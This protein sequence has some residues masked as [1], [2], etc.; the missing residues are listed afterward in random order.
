M[1]ILNC[2]QAGRQ[3]ERSR[4]YCLLH[5]RM[6]EVLALKTPSTVFAGAKINVDEVC[7]KLTA[8]WKKIHLK[9][10]YLI[11]HSL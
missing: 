9:K 11:Y 1:L 3:V 5:G 2:L 8:S 6:S 10:I 7:E 4:Y